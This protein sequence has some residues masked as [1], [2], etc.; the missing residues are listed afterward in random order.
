MRGVLPVFEPA[1]AR[2]PIRRGD[3]RRVTFAGLATAAVLLG[4]A[5]A[6]AVLRPSGGQDTWLAL[7]LGLA[8]AAATAIASIM[9]FF[10]TA[11]ARVAPAR[12][13]ARITGIVLIAG[14][15]L[16]VAGGVTWDGPALAVAGGMAYLVGL[17]VIAAN[18]FLPL[19]S[20]LGLGLR[21]VPLAY[22][23][24]LGC[25]AAGVAL[26]T[27]MLAGWQPVVADWAA[28]K[29]A[30]AWLNVFG[31]LSVVIAATLIHLAPTVAGARIRPRRSASLALI[32]LAS[33]AP[34]VAL[35]FASGS[36]PAVRVGGALFFVGAVALVS[37]GFGVHRDRGR[38]TGDAG[39][40]AFTDASL[41]IGP[42][43]F[44]VGVGFAVWPLFGIGA[45]ASA[46]S[47]DRLAAPLAL[48]WVAQILIGSWTHL[49]PAIGPG[50]Q[51]VHARQRRRLGRYGVT[52]W[53]LWNAGVALVIL[54]GIVGS[55][56]LGTIGMGA[57]AAGLLAALALLVGSVVI[58]PRPLPPPAAAPVVDP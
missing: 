26:A 15:A 5:G 1:G 8:G 58:D 25:V 48:G 23:A 56:I 49:V 7:H 18:A 22:G 19:R 4:L 17:V 9:P 34:V 14:G 43:W 52:R 51:A 55:Q 57:L 31:F 27:A 11:L 47:V 3:D 6:A 37:H 10:T 42:V 54:G 36:D 38:W 53:L 13:V 12:P 24:A 2:T 35:G 50:D 45:S 21:F 41:T 44:L 40:H 16:V 20:T 28:L 39:W 46:W 30:H 32:G 29:P 33:G